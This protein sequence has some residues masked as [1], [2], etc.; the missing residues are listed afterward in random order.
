MCEGFPAGALLVQLMDDVVIQIPMKTLDSF[1]QLCSSNLPQVNNQAIPD[2]GKA[3]IAE[4]LAEADKQ[5]IDG[6]HEHIQLLNAAAV[7]MRVLSN[8][9]EVAF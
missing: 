9:Q 5:L 1:D 7:I 8:T 6:A 4:K 3:T 2:N